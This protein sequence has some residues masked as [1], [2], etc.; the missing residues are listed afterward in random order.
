MRPV[1]RRGFL[2]VSGSSMLLGAASAGGQQRP[3]PQLREDR[4]GTVR[5]ESSRYAFQWSS[6]QDQLQLFD[7]QGRVTR[8]RLSPVVVV[9]RGA[10]G[11]PRCEA[12]KVASYVANGSLLEV[13]YGG[14]N[15]GAT[16][17]L[18]NVY[19]RVTQ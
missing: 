3:A 12:G 5:S 14:V 6:S 15:G 16:L 19:Q 4:S 18:D 1:T 13:R 17:R 7:L 8:G 2:E 11:A 9:S 10:G